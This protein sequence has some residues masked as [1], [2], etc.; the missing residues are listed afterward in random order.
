[1]AITVPASP[2]DILNGRYEATQIADCLH[3]AYWLAG[4]DDVAALKN[5]QW[6]HEYFARQAAAMGYRLVPLESEAP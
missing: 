1:M 5:L 4:R 6:A 3:S 2:L